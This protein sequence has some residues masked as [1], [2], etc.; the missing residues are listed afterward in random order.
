MLA[1]IVW[2]S[3]K[4]WTENHPIGQ[5]IF[6]IP[7]IIAKTLAA[8]F[9]VRYLI[10]RYIIEKRQYVL[11]YI[12]TTAALIAT[13]FVDLLRDYFGRGLGWDDLPSTG[14]IIVHSFYYSAADLSAPFIVI[15]AKKY[16]ENQAQ[17]HQTREQQKEAELRLLRSQLNPHFLFNNLNTLDA[18]VDTRPETAKEYIG[19]L[20]NLY[21]YL[22][23]T[24][25]EDI[26]PVAQ[27]IQWAEDYFFLIQTRYGSS[28][29]F[30]IKTDPDVDMQQLYIPTGALQTV[31]ENVIKH[32]S[33][34][35]EKEI[36]TQLI[37]TEKA[38][39]VENTK[40]LTVDRESLGTGLKNLEERY[41][42]LFDTTISV[43]DASERFKVTLPCLPMKS[44]SVA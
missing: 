26:M 34:S 35:A 33:A 4:F 38:L 11:F 28:Y 12:L 2:L 9:I 17:L 30:H 7:I 37:A 5:I 44:N 21:R 22:I 42:L 24:A 23:S 19:R 8:F 20:S 29:R 3:L 14:Y 40:A 16:F 10:Q 43:E 15:I 27:E 36:I 31:L 18:L 6:D 13:G 1:G 41:A 32:N 39:I 25:S